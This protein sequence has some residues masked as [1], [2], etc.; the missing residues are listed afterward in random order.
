MKI[1]YF[2][3]ITFKNYMNETV[4]FEVIS[5]LGGT[6][7]RLF[8]LFLAVQYRIFVFVVIIFFRT[9]H[10]TDFIKR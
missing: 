10:I 6:T 7:F 5:I 9:E 8:P 1:Q 3:K 4:K 2:C